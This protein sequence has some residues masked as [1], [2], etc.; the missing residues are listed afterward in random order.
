MAEVVPYNCDPDRL[1]AILE[2]FAAIGAD[3]KIIQQEAAPDRGPFLEISGA[4]LRFVTYKISRRS[5]EVLLSIGLGSFPK[6]QQ[7][8]GG[9]WMTVCR[10]R[11]MFGYDGS[12]DSRSLRDDLVNMLHAECGATEF[13]SLP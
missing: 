2:C 12:D 1:S 10:R 9:A 5:S 7:A 6:R 13:H 8:D 3:A 4:R 11:S